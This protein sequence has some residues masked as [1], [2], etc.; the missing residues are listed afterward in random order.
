M[1]SFKETDT[2]QKAVLESVGRFKG[3]ALACGR[4]IISYQEFD[5]VSER[6]AAY[7][8]ARGINPGTVA[9]LSMKR[10][11]KMI[12]AVYGIFKTGACLLPIPFDLPEK[13]REMILQDVD[14]SIFFTDADY[15]A[16]LEE[17]TADSRKYR[18]A[19]P[20]DDALILYTSGST[21]KPKGV[22]HSQSSK[23]FSK[24]Q[25][26]DHV[27][28][29]GIRCLP[30]DTIIAKTNINF[31]SAYIFEILVA[32]LCGRKLVILNDEEQNSPK[33]V[34]KAIAENENSSVFITPSQ[35]VSFLK[36]KSFREAFKELGTLVVA[37]EMLRSDARD[38]ILECAGEKTKIIN[39]YASSECHL[40]S[41][42]DVRSDSYPYT[43]LLPGVDAR[44]IN[45]EGMECASG[46]MGELAVAGAGLFSRYTNSDMR[47]A[48]IEGR[49]YF[50]T[51]D[52][53][54][55][56]DDKRIWIK[57]RKDRMI[58]YHGLRIELSDIERSICRYPGIRE[59]A[60][61][62][63]RT[64]GST[65]VLC[66]Y[67]VSD[68]ETDI[69]E[70]RSFLSLYLPQ[71]L[72][73]VGMTRLEALPLNP[74]N[75]TDY[76]ELSSRV[77]IPQSADAEAYSGEIS[78]EKEKLLASVLSQIWESEELR[79]SSNLFGLGLDSLTAFR[80]IGE[81]KERGYELSVAQIFAHPVLGELAL[82]MNRCDADESAEYEDGSILPATGV[83]I[84]W[85]SDITPMKKIQGLYVTSSFICETD[86]TQDGFRERVA[87]IIK[88]HPALRTK[89]VFDKGMS[90]QVISDD[91]I[92]M[93]EYEDIIDLHKDVGDP[94]EL[95]A[96]QTEHVSAAKDTILKKI[97]E[98]EELTAFAAF[99]FRI[100]DKACYIICI[101]N[102]VSV[103]GSSMNILMQELSNAAIDEE[104]DSY[105]DFLKYIGKKSSMDRA[106]EF[107]R[108]YLKDADF[109]ALPAPAASK[110]SDE[111]PKPDFRGV[112]IALTSDETE[113]LEEKC[114]S[115]G[116]TTVGFIMYL[117][118]RSLMRVLKK[119]AII[120]QMLTFG[121]GVPVSG[122]DRSV[123]CFIEYVPIV[124]RKDDSPSTFQQGYLMAEQYNYLPRHTL[125]K[126][127]LG[128]DKTPGLAP[129]LI[130]EIF[131]PVRTRGYFREISERDYAHMVMSNFIVMEDG[132][133]TIY[134]HYDANKTDG[135]MFVQMTD[136]LK[137]LL[138]KECG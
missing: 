135:E 39:I 103:D 20:T 121:R 83:Q 71:T 61:T 47:T 2:I 124:I 51:G 110:D 68:D 132:H 18:F 66:A 55:M 73:P 14:I 11:E 60:V 30:I 93:S 92:T 37:G 106:V 80:I 78:T 108:D 58:K 48:K 17:K 98:S 116:V 134:F 63:N 16:A 45:E 76:N 38:T 40:M 22:C 97:A 53:A 13:R 50:L 91:A 79:P 70:L 10:S 118:G 36:D 136:E 95:S 49:S 107:W 7:L 43:T 62:L 81:L 115:M 130:S 86:Y 101:G 84:Y 122:M 9:A 74:N 114:R 69:D 138:M 21:G 34:G 28:D 1:D 72:I 120:F 41:A 127:A 31:I 112:S 113:R 129:Y 82:L 111:E 90:G 102:H 89:I 104:Q 123:G 99:C 77:F 23:L 119:D 59:C 128:L 32:P 12:M 54:L 33:A 4:K 100:S 65:E 137:E 75:K 109:S 15:E 24:D 52:K 67:Y 87:A 125:Y 5:A 35:M 94:F 126:S 29:A 64:P 117:Y 85:G 25:F 27:S 42:A 19:G 105:T 133:I 96:K 6:I 44:L 3:T 57:G 88:R 131:P 8:M 56:S 46:E 26:P